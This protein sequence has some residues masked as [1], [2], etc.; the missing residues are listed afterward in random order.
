MNNL[1]L[2]IVFLG[3]VL[4]MYCAIPIY[5][6]ASQDEELTDC[7]TI[8]P[9]P[10]I[11]KPTEELAPTDEV[12][13]EKPESTLEK[14][15]KLVQNKHFHDAVGM[16]SD[17]SLV[18][19]KTPAEEMESDF[20]KYD[21]AGY[22]IDEYRLV[23]T[24]FVSQDTAIIK[25]IMKTENSGKAAQVAEDSYVLHWENQWKLNLNHLVDYTDLFVKKQTIRGVTIRPLRFVR[26]T[27]TLHLQFCLDNANKQNI[28]WGWGGAG[29]STFH[30]ARD[31]YDSQSSGIGGI[32]IEANRGNLILRTAI[33]GFYEAL[34]DQVDVRGFTLASKASPLVPANPSDTWNYTFMFSQQK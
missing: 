30:F 17:Y 34:P 18:F 22:K 5:A 6:S 23:N 14:Y 20:V 10:E 32:Q 1:K 24:Q 16:F 4:C 27:N 9:T 21:M 19:F 7:K 25:V 15:F 11:V 8:E 26:Y 31:Q 12:I 13:Q 33:A 29:Q 2:R 28:L 3:A